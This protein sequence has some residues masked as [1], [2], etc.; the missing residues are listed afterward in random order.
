LA[1]L[2]ERVAGV[3]QHSET[4]EQVGLCLD[5]SVGG[6]ERKNGW[7]LAEHAGDEVPWR[8]QAVLGR[9]CWDAD[10]ARDIRR[11]Y[12][13]ERLGDPAGVLILDGPAS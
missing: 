9:G 1:E 13:I 6:V 5:G 11:D 4:R 2:K 12:V 7:Q 3:F 8:M 10:D